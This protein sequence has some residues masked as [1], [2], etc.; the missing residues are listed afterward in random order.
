MSLF[1]KRNEALK[2]LFRPLSKTLDTRDEKSPLRKRN[3]QFNDLRQAATTTMTARK[4]A[5]GKLRKE[6]Q[7]PKYGSIHCPHRH[8][9]K[10]WLPDDLAAC[11][12]LL[13]SFE[14]KFN[15]VLE[16]RRKVDVEF[17]PDTLG[18]TQNIYEQYNIFNSDQKQLFRELILA[19][20]TEICRRKANRLDLTQQT[21]IPEVVHLT[22]L[23]IVI[24]IRDEH[25]AALNTDII[26]EIRNS[27][28]DKFACPRETIRFF[29]RRNCCDCLKEI[30]YKL[31]DETQRTSRC[32]A[33]KEVKNI[34]E[35]IQCDVC[36]TQWCSRECQVTDKLHVGCKRYHKQVNKKKVR[37]A[38]K[39]A[40]EPEVVTTLRMIVLA[41]A[42]MIFLFLLGARTLIGLPIQEFEYLEVLERDLGISTNKILEEDYYFV[43]V[44][45]NYALYQADFVEAIQ[46]VCDSIE[47]EGFDFEGNCLSRP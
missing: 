2:S 29:H 17:V 46:E 42:I 45:E 6:N 5:Q 15:D 33:C 1:E 8:V 9:S 19:H 38:S 37:K 10:E 4:K 30:Y 36:K 39:A 44:D 35:M 20:G 32:F 21:E 11:S 22:Q 7:R 24:E 26:Y 16:I 3:L 18:L 31:K 40:V 23:L 13:S 41:W 27:S 47:V 34:R 12:L 25:S 14:T 43:E 28:G